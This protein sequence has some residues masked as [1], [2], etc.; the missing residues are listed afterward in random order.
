M[1]KV[2]S[3]EGYF[4]FMRERESIRLKKIAG[5]SFPWTEDKILQEYKF[6]NVKRLHDKTTQ[7]LKTE[8]YDKNLDA[9]PELQ[10]LNAAIFRYFGT[11]EFALALGFQHDF[12]PQH[13]KNLAEQRAQE[14]KRVFTGAYVITNQGIK[15]PKR[16]VVVDYFLTGLWEKALGIVGVAQRGGSWEKVIGTL[17]TIQGFGGTGFMAKEVVLDTMLT[18]F[19]LNGKPKDNNT[20]C[21]C[22]PGAR[23][24]L[25]RIAGRPLTFNQKEE[26]FLSEMVNLFAESR[27]H[28]PEDYVVLELH[29]IQFQLCEYDKYLRVANGEGRPRSK[30]KVVL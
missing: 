13:I 19:W 3:V 20:W 27:S 4:A 24:G 7:V 28:W 5:D 30:Y 14:K 10:L 23:R 18:N 21:P 22:G 6:T 25:N 11:Y 12:N 17:R 16:E 2:A 9:A 26:L 15:A 8:I 29:D 1:N